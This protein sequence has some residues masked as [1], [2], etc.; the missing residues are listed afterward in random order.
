M[1]FTLVYRGP[2]KANGKP[3][4]KQAIRRVFHEQLRELWKHPPLNDP[5]PP[6]EIVTCDANTQ[7]LPRVH[8]TGEFEF[9]PLVTQKLH[10]IAE[11]KITMLRPGPPGWIIGA[12]GD[13]DNRLKTLL[14]S[15]KMPK[16]V[17]E[18]PKGD[19]PG[20]NETPFYCL[21][22]DDGLVTKL[23]V[24]TEQLLE[25]PESP[26]F[27]HLLVHVTTKVTRLS[28]DNMGLG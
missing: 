11:L 21:L 19:L 23:S 22:E 4:D 7:K 15:L 16:E 9:A 25:K 20:D 6:D 27:V 12:G 5:T 26:K 28:W 2:L 8:E 18:I 24:D 3:K 1:E 10:M 13:I 14:D 17:S